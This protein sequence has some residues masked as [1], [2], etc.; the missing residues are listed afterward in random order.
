MIYFGVDPGQDGAIAAVSDQRSVVLLARLPHTTLKKKRVVD[1]QALGDLIRGVVANPAMSFAVVEHQ[2]ARVII[3][4]GKGGK[5][6]RRVDT[7]TTAFALGYA[8]G[9]IRGALTMLGVSQASYEPTVWKKAFGLVG[10][11]KDA[12][13]AVAKDLFPAVSIVPPGGRVDHDGLAEALLMAEF[14]RRIQ[15]SQSEFGGSAVDVIGEVRYDWA[16]W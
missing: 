13:K 1:V 5:P 11:S 12:S 7:P 3:A 6:G 9:A 8:F 16:S 2:H 15:T 14:A 4:P 10:T